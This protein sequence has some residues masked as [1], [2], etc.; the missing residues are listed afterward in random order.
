[1]IVA[2]RIL[3]FINFSLTLIINLLFMGL[4]LIFIIIIS[5][6]IVVLDNS[7]V[8]HELVSS[9]I[10]NLLITFQLHKTGTN[11]V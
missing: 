4:D 9:R 8:K 1:M 11:T 2:Y 3:E 5:K 6:E 7:C 10:F